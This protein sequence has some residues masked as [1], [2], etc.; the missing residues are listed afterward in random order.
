MKLACVCEIETQGRPE[1]YVSVCYDSH[2]ALKALQA[3]KT[4]SPL[5]RQCQKAL[6]DISIRHTVGLHWVPGHARVHGSEIPDKLA[7]GGSTQTFVGP[8]PSLGVSRHNI[9]NNIKHWVDNQHLAMWRG[10]CS[11]QRQ[12]QKLI[13]SPSLATKA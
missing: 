9:N 6:N 12:A 2:M 5:V 11:T 1:K 8:E 3:A 7:R 13:S 10:P 4:K